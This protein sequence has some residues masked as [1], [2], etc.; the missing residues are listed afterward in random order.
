MTAEVPGVE[1]G[2]GWPVERPQE[3]DEASR[4]T[5]ALPGKPVGLGWAA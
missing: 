2:L 4:E 3:P 5:S 1:S